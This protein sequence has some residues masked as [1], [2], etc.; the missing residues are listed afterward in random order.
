MSHNGD[1]DC[2]TSSDIDDYTEQAYTQIALGELANEDPHADIVE[3]HEED[4]GPGRLPPDGLAKIL[5]DLQSLDEVGKQD[6]LAQLSKNI[7]LD[8]DPTNDS[9]DKMSRKRFV[10]ER[11][12]RKLHAMKSSRAS[13]KTVNTKK[14]TKRISK[15]QQS[16]IKRRTEM[17][18]VLDRMSV[19]NESNSDKLAQPVSGDCD[20][21]VAM[22]V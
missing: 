15:A 11:L 8:I 10:E 17:D 9:L 4:L 7:H 16:Q 20:C 14:N 21:D 5:A 2:S 6:Y 12:R 13:K 19:S 1:S 22:D 3:E 18:N